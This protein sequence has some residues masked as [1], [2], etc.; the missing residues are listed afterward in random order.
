MA[1]QTAPGPSRPKQF[2]K[3][4]DS[5]LHAPHVKQY[6]AK[7]RFFRIQYTLVKGKLKLLVRPASLV[8]TNMCDYSGAFY[9]RNYCHAYKK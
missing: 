2:I 5:M 3:N 8:I 7:K 1:A 4:F 6:Q 9:R